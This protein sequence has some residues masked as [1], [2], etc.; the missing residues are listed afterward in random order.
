MNTVVS[1]LPRGLQATLRFLHGQFSIPKVQYNSHN[2][3]CTM[4]MTTSAGTER[5]Y[6]LAQASLRALVM[7][8]KAVLVRLCEK[9]NLKT[10]SP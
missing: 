5:M 3:A 7:L 1:Q 6:K 9:N 4:I 8:P 2:E 10:S